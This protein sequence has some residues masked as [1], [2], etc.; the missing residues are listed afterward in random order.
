[1]TRPTIAVDLDDVL[2]LHAAAFVR[3]SNENYGTELTPEEYDDMWTNL[4]GDMTWDEIEARAAVFHTPENTLAYA[5][6]DEASPVLARLRERF[7]L[8]I[9]TARPKHLMQVT[10]QWL[11]EHHTDVFEEVHFVPLWLPNNT[12]TKADICKQIGA[13]YLIDDTVRHCNIAAE[14]GITA[15]LFG[16]YRWNRN[17]IDPRVQQVHNWGEVEAY[18]GGVS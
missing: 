8:V 2:A 16:N 18:F 15:L 4:W 12:V 14:S 7:R 1:M 6:I 10:H 11:A 13:E 5:K 17:G 3:F 9:V